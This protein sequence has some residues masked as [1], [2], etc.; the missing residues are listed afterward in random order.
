MHQQV[1]VG[2]V[3]MEEE[4]R[5]T[6]MKNMCLSDVLQTPIPGTQRTQTTPEGLSGLRGQ[7]GLNS[8]CIL[9]SKQNFHQEPEYLKGISGHA[10]GEQDY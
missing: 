6:C 7:G 9:N 10:F 4:M 3:L 1:G 8:L 2:C 5:M